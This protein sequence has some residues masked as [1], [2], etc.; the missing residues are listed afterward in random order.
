MTRVLAALVL[1]ALTAGPWL[2]LPCVHSCGSG[3]QVSAVKSDCHGASTSLPRVA[4]VHD[5]HGHAAALADVAKRTE[6][7]SPGVA[8]PGG[9]SVT[10]LIGRVAYRPAIDRAAASPPPPFPVIPLRI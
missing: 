5:C 9:G 1:A 4:A 6:S 3:R 7:I 2:R 10:T 8:V